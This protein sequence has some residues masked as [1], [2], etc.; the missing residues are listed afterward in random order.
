M[1]SG[2]LMDRSP[3][4]KD[5]R[6]LN[7]RTYA[8]EHARQ[9]S[10]GWHAP[11]LNRWERLRA[12]G[13]DAVLERL[14]PSEIA[15]HT[16][17]AGEEYWI[18]PGERWRLASLDSAGSLE[19]APH[20]QDALSSSRP[21]AARERWLAGV[22]EVEVEGVSDLRNLLDMLPEGERRLCLGAFDWTDAVVAAKI[23]LR[24]RLSWH[25]LAAESN[26]NFAALA[27]HVGNPVNLVDYLGRD[28]AVIEAALSMAAR[29]VGGAPARFR[30]I[31]RRHVAIEEA[32]LFPAYDTTDDRGRMVRGLL[33]EHRYIEAALEGADEPGSL[34]RL[35]R[36]L[37]AHDEKEE[38]LVYPEI[39][40]H[41]HDSECALLDR[42]LTF[43]SQFA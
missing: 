13:G 8:G 5:L 31:L 20:A 4:P 11:R 38:L 1:F 35:W 41:E 9:W 17:P 39:V 2:L 18:E 16:L 33:R 19:V 37:E 30:G 3:L 40:T 25:P 36:L 14:E 32:L 15:A 6:Y 23:I 29:G 42:V 43:P 10:T 26:G 24:G 21:Q 7:S 22:K 12:N 28:H 27:I 34:R